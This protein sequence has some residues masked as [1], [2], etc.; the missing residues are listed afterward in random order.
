MVCMT[1]YVVIIILSIANFLRT[2]NHNLRYLGITCLT[3]MI[4]VQPK[5]VAEHQMV[6]VEC[7]EDADETLRVRRENVDQN[8]DIAQ[9]T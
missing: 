5:V 1:S 7:L 8:H 4:A 9:D 3:D 2:D 6:I